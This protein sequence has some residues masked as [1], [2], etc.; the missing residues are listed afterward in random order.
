[1]CYLKYI[2]Y[3]VRHQILVFRW[4]LKFGILWRGLCHDLSKFLPDEFFAHARYFFGVVR[5]KKALDR[6]WWKHQRRNKHHWQYWTV[7]GND[8]A[9]SALDMPLVYRKEM[10]ADWLAK[11]LSEDKSGLYKSYLNH[12]KAIILHGNTRAWLEDALR[13]L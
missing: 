4:C 5:N 8:G 13:V 10:L 2:G 3:L 1:M 11:W 7:I 9:L 6:A 12:K